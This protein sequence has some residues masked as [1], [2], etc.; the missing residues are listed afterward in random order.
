MQQADARA[1]ALLS[2]ADLRECRVRRDASEAIATEVRAA[3]AR[4]KLSQS[5]LAEKLGWTQ[6]KV[7]RRLRSVGQLSIEELEQISDALGVSITELTSPAA[8]AS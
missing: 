3:L 5:E 1:R 8:A 4:Q 7:S 2:V 6:V